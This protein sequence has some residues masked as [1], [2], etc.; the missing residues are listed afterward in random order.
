MLTVL[1]QITKKLFAG[2]QW[3]SCI[4][5]HPE[6]DNFIVGSLNKKVL[7]FDTD[8]QDTPYKSLSYHEKGVR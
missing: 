6:G 1:Q 3:N 2:S 8:L 5:V 4:D 7:W